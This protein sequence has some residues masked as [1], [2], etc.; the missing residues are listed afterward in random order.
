SYFQS[1]RPTRDL[2]SFPTR[3][4]SDLLRRTGGVP[5]ALRGHRAYRPGLGHPSSGNDC[6]LRPAQ[7]A[8]GV[9]P[10]RFELSDRTSPVP[11][12][13]SRQLPGDLEGG[14]TDMSRLW[15]PIHR[16]QVVLGRPDLSFPLVTAHGD[17]NTMTES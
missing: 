8:R 14:G 1:P 16:A 13:Q 6:G 17:A 5:P 2:H 15:R 7:P 11:E 4:S 3:R 10:R 12:D 9:A